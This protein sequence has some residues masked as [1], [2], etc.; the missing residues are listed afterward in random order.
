MTVLEM[1]SNVLTQ[2]GVYGIGGFPPGNHCIYYEI[3]SG[4]GI[5]TRVQSKATGRACLTVG[6]HQ[7]PFLGAQAWCGGCN[8]RVRVIS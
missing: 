6:D 8:D 5:T 1:G 2:I 4:D 7:A 3:R